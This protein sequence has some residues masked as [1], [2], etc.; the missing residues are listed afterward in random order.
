VLQGLGHYSR[1]NALLDL[2]TI[3]CYSLDRIFFGSCHVIIRHFFH[4][5]LTREVVE[6]VRT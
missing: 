4:L 6:E 5:Y 1:T 3:D 2:C